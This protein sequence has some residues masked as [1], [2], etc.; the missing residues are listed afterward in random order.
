MDAKPEE[1]RRFPRV[2][3]KVPLR[4]HLRGNPEIDNTLT[5]DIGL[6]GIGFI[7]NGFIPAKTPL[8]LEIPVFSRLLC[9]IGRV[10]WSQVLP[11]SNRYRVGVEFVQIDQKDSDFLRDYLS[12]NV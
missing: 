6:G 1:K 12:M 3:L 9:P 11:H 10:A 7:N 4:F 8:D 5:E 2:R